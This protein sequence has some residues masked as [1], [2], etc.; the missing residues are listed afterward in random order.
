MAPILKEALF[1]R[2]ET[3]ILTSA[4]LAAGG[5]FT[6]LEERLGLSLP[7]SRVTV[8][9][10]L[11]SPFDFSAQC[12]FGIPTDVPEP[13]DD[14]SGH[15]AAVAR[16]L[17]ELA[18]ASDGGIFGLFTSHTALRRAA[19]AI[20]GEV[21]ARWPLLVQG[22]GQRDQLLRRFREAGSAILLGTDS[23]WE[24]VDVPGRALRVLILAKLPFK[25]PSDPLTAARLERL[26]EAG[27]DGFTHYLVPHAA[28]KLKQ[29][30]GRLIRSKTD[31]GAVVLLDRRVVTKRYGE[32]ILEGLP[33]ASKAIG[34]WSDI[35]GELEEFFAMHGIGAP[36]SWS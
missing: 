33:P 30:F 18:H 4:T 6:F 35:R 3:V 17:L 25:V 24:G 21:G 11:P 10:V 26:N 27:V 2:T 20:R 8:R 22:E 19:D 14:E 36:A 15:S 16:V 13:R 5:E 28:L 9:E 23:F 7:P 31:V 32:M 12:V 34:N 1:D 29:G